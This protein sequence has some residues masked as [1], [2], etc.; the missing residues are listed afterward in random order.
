MAVD[1]T[2]FGFTATESLAYNALLRR[3]PSSGYAVA[4]HLSI[5]RA[6]AYQALNGL[7][8]KAAADRLDETPQRYRAVRPDAVLSFVTAAN[9]GR[10]DQLEAQM[11][12]LTQK[13]G[14]TNVRLSGRRALLDVLL[15]TAAKESGQID[16]LAPPGILQALSPAWRMRA[17]EGRT[18][19][20]WALGEPS[21]A[22]PVPLEGT[23]ELERARGIFDAEMVIL[24][25]RDV[26]VIARVTEDSASGYWTSDATLVG[27]GLAALTH[28]TRP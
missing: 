19:T 12:A 5:A 14:E 3:G 8:S 22:F 4:K 18:S 1:L 28:L 21:S 24:V 15:R 26:A 13:E 27:L 11:S 23:V 10:L 16:C 20:L 17:M 25:A 6:N 2:P 7:V 9:A